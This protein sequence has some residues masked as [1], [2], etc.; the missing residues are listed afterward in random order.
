M[1]TEIIK[2]ENSDDFA[3]LEKAGEIIRKSGL[4]AFPTETVYGLGGNALDPEASAKIYMAKGRPS[5]NPLIVHLS[6]PDEAGL[7]C[8][9]GDLYHTL[10][11]RFMPGPLTVI[12]KKKRLNGRFIIPD[13][14]TGGLDSAAV[15]C[16]S[17]PIAHRLISAA[18]VPIAAPSANRSG[19]P[20][21]TTAEHV[22]KDLSGRID[23]IIDG[24]PC[25]FGL[26]STVVKIEGDSLTILRPGA[27]T[28]EDLEPYCSSVTV[29]D[30]EPKPGETP[31]SPGMKYRHYSPSKSFYLVNGAD[32][33]VLEFF[34]DRQNKERCALIVFEEDAAFLEDRNLFIL[35]TRNDLYSQAHS[36]FVCLRDA[37][38]S[39]TDVIY[40]RF[41]ERSGI[42]LAL[43]NRLIRAC[44]HNVINL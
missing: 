19:S 25:N 20:S 11:S 33:D 5:D 34:I 21:P 24:G 10:S 26:E 40:A 42:G 1:Q 16:P 3:V 31:L 22:I 28:A 44:G 29:S 38:A 13:E 39:D 15:R 6:D 18:G 14:T 7:Y 27:V 32:S 4:V 17:E 30:A 9:T 41:P 36:L 8:E 23:M 35:G 43:Y 2:I 12:L 37:D